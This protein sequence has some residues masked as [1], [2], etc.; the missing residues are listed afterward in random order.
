M[1]ECFDRD[2]YPSG[3][4]V[5]QAMRGLALV[6][7]RAVPGTDSADDESATFAISVL[8]ERS[9]TEAEAVMVEVLLNSREEEQCV[10]AI[11]LLALRFTPIAAAAVAR[12]LLDPAR[13][14]RVYDR[15]AALP[16]ASS[17]PVLVAAAKQVLS[18]SVG[19]KHVVALFQAP[20]RRSLMRRRKAA[21]LVANINGSAPGASH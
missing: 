16:A 10:A 8:K 13:Q 7:L 6:A 20:K 15:I 11:E 21:A 5:G 14:P 12:T 1:K 18:E 4:E 3:V 2:G 19:W 17:S 9:S